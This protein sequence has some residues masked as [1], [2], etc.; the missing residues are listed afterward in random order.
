MKTLFI[1]EEFLK[2]SEIKCQDWH[3]DTEERDFLENEVEYV[4]L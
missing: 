4:D 1:K 2:M 3:E